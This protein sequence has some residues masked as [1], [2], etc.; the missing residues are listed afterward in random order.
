M[1]EVRS[2]S[3]VLLCTCFSLCGDDLLRGSVAIGTTASIS[4]RS[5]GFFYDF[6]KARFFQSPPVRLNISTA[7]ST[8]VFDRSV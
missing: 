4:P 3:V 2:R 1:G 8:V 6:N 5:G 7:L